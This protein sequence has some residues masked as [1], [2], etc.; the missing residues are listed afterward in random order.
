MCVVYT[1]CMMTPTLERPGSDIPAVRLII[2]DADGGLGSRSTT[3][4]NATPDSA[5]EFVMAAIAAA[6]ANGNGKTD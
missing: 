4:Y 2:R 1:S 3:I 6:K 5:F